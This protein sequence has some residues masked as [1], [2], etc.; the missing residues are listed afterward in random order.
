MSNRAYLK[1]TLFAGLILTINQGW[2]A[3][4]SAPVKV[5]NYV[6]PAVFASALYQGMTVPVFIRYEGDESMQ[7]SQQKIADAILTIKDAE[8][9]LNQI[10]INDLPERTQLSPHIKALLEGLQDKG[11]G[12][13]QRVMI[14]KNASLT[15]DTR[16][17]YLELTVSREAL[18][19]AILPRTNILGDSTAQDLSSVLNYSLG[20]YYNKYGNN[21]NASSY[22]TLD[23][24]LSLREHHLNIN[25]SLYGIGTGNQQ[26]ELYRTMY[27]R[28]Y[29][30][31]RLAMGMVD[32]WNLQSIASMSALNS[33]RIYGMSYGNKSS[34]QIEDNTL[35][36]VPVT[37]F[38][39][40]AGEVHIYRDGKLLSIQNF[41]MGSYELD[42]SHLPFGIYNVD[43][44]I[45]V[46]GRVVGSR[47]ANIN[48]T[49]SRK[50]SIT[51]D[52]SWQM[53]GGS[54]E[55]KKMDYRHHNN[56]NYGQQNTWIAGV[57]AATRQPWLSGVDL[58]TTLYGFDQNGVNQTEAN[59]IFNNAL[60]FNQQG[61]IGTDGSWQSISTANLSLPEGYGNVWMSRQ[62]SAIGDRLPLQQN[63]YVTVG[64]TANLKKFGSFL[65]TLTVSRSNNKYTG[66]TYTNVD[67]EQSLLANRYA[68]VSL[69]AGVQNY[70]YDSGENLRDKYINIDVSIP[71]A[72]WF[73][74]GVSSQNGNMLANATLRKRFDNSP[75]TQVG[76]SLSKQLKQKNENA[77]GYRS[78]DYA[79]NGYLGYD[80]KY[81][82]GTLSVSRSAQRNSNY[83]LSSQ[84]SLAWTKNTIYAAKGTQSS[85]LVVNTNFSEQGN[86][87]AQI[88]GQNYPLSGKRN[89]I[90]LP[91][92][93]E[94]KVELMNDK[95]SE[96]SVDIVSGR[97]S[98]VVLYPGNVST[99]N[100]EIK[101]LITVFGRVKDSRGGYYANADIHNHIGK[102]RT[103]EQGEFAMDVDKRY[104]V[105]TLTDKF[106][107][108][109]EADLDLKGA[110]GAVW[111]GDISCEIQQQTASLKG[112]VENVY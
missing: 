31:R 54:L 59:V 36:L 23:N 40:A 13:G 109:C 96:D 79:A 28:D 27:E 5:G 51:G 111:M 91:P 18:Q 24:T 44:Q 10:T 2:S 69:R 61:L 81:N 71:F 70:Q 66:N 101:Q 37:V 64:G 57:A 77:K 41:S 7:R 112:N 92:Y 34:T 43:I 102:T 11:I 46:N 50:S 8:F 108:L 74:T 84:G 68:S 86:M 53:F 29:Q 3:N 26:G 16:S 67:Y 93:T 20:S 32:T 100:P 105:I 89:F 60:S 55:Y 42:T 94:Y 15:L 98:S 75:V 22:L 48:K 95:N 88:N 14:N 6:I 97:R 73:S 72:T 56:I 19:A 52:F 38:L 99:I 39:P 63:D 107:G 47:T 17:F 9:S 83:N 62:Y 33:S 1:G 76:A 85:G 78:D 104:P 30:G 90:S 87:I 45:V 25:G 21:D 80:T 49:F 12:D 106:G 110:K 58:K 65:G 4:S 103:D 82:A 35:S